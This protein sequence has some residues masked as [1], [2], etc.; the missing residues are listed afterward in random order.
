[1][2]LILGFCGQF[3]RTGFFALPS[4]KL[5][6]KPPSKKVSGFSYVLWLVIDTGVF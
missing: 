1:M 6:V 2:R 5:E 3:V 4:T